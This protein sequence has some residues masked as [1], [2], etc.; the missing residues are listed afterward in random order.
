MFDKLKSLLTKGELFQFM[1]FC[2]VGL[3]NTAVDFFVF[4]ASVNWLNFNVYAAQVAAYSIATL[5]SYGLNRLFTF[6]DKKGKVGLQLAKFLTVNL[7]SLLT[8]LAL[9]YFFSD[10]L[11]L[12]TVLAKVLIAGFT[13]AINYLGNRLWVF[14]K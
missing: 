14:R 10:L 4:F 2:M 7:T 5:N 6:R 11:A 13:T 1:R 9:L 12:N 8:S 3:V